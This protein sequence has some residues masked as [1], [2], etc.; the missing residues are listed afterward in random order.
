MLKVSKISFAI[1][2]SILLVSCANIDHSYQA[3]QAD[4]QQY[5]ELTKQY[6][7]QE[8]WW[9]LYQD[10][11]LNQLVE[12]GLANNKDLAKAAIAVNI[13]LYKANLLGAALVPNFTGVL[14]SSASK[15]IHIGGN[16]LT[17]HEGSLNVSYTLDLWRNLADSASAAEWTHAAT[18][19]DLEAARISLINSIV[20]V[21]YRLAYLNDAI[22]VTEQT[23][24]YYSKINHIMHNKLNLGLADSAST[25]QAQQ[26]VLTARNMLIGYQTQRKV[27]E[28]MLRDLLN[29]KPNDALNIN[30][31][32]ILSV[33]NV[34]INL[35]V[36][37]STIA[38]RPDVKAMQYRL[39]SAF[40]NA[41][42]MQKSW[43]PSITLAAGLS[44]KGNKVDNTFEAPIAS[45]LIKVN[46][47]F[48]SWNTVKWNVK[49]SEANYSVALATFEQS[50]TSALNDIDK[51]YFAYT[52]AQQNLANLKQTHNYNMRI[53]QYYRNRYNAGIAELKDWLNA[54]NMEKR[55][56]L[57]ILDAKYNLIQSENAVYS[58]MGG[59]YSIN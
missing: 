36:P 26:A 24:K 48:L 39:N 2:T 28:T 40:K 7:I 8:N 23:I 12:K 29:L 59:Y 54:A 44:S 58:S 33:K 14:G 3:S 19:K 32:K 18:A 41:K 11:Q 51:N 22:K 35:N 21:Y 31:P 38:N 9:T 34:G 17:I 30:Y 10:S 43:F 13:A 37:F 57:A 27:A 20:T 50:I 4:F 52:Q 1:A 55:S 47:P 49:I 15:N 25:D 16:S 45:G 53:T 6:K 56:E 46:L 42:A 5:E